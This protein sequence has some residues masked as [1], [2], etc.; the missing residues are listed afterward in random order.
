MS[1]LVHE[2]RAVLLPL[3]AARVF[4]A[5]IDRSCSSRDWADS[6]QYLHHVRTLHPK[7]RLGGIA[8][9]LHR[10][11]EREQ[12]PQAVNDDAVIGNSQF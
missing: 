5:A 10:C 8:S 7:L 3:F 11:C 2:R 1:I 9:A 6:A 12:V 4:F